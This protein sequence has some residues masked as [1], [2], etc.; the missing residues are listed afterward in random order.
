MTHHGDTI[1]I[2]PRDRID[3]FEDWKPPETVSTDT[4]SH[5]ADRSEDAP[6]GIV[7]GEER[8]CITIEEGAKAEYWVESRKSIGSASL[9]FLLYVIGIGCLIVVLWIQAIRVAVAA[10][11]SVPTWLGG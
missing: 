11:W 6:L 8:R 5:E 3:W 10:G 7:P 1:W 9:S 2:P 4:R